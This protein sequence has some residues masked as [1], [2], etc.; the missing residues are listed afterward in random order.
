MKSESKEEE[1]SGKKEYESAMTD[2]SS[3]EYEF[4]IEVPVHIPYSSNKSMSTVNKL[5]SDDRLILS[6]RGRPLCQKHHQQLTL[7]CLECPLNSCLKCKACDLD[8][9]S[10]LIS[11]ERLYNQSFKTFGNST[12]LFYLN[13]PMLTFFFSNH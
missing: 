12:S 1:V 7:V 8:L 6:N 9:H 3:E 10:N 4:E 11:I 2:L 5:K 13:I